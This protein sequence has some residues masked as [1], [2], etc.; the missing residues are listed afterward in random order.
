[1]SEVV[2]HAVYSVLCGMCHDLEP[3]GLDGQ[4]AGHLPELRG[5]DGTGI[6]DCGGVAVGMPGVVLDEAAALAGQPS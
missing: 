1:M 5:Q 2:L 4:A 3:R 6:R